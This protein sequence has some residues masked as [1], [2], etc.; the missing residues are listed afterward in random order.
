[1][2]KGCDGCCVFY[3][4]C[5]MWS[6]KSSCMGSMSV[7]QMLYVSYLHHVAVLNAEFCI[8]CSLLMLVEDAKATIWK[9]H[10]PEPDS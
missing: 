3:L 7:M 8:T 2:C 4:Y 5:D 10:T 6:S 9:R 1:M